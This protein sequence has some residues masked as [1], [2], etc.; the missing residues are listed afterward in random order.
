MSKR[1]LSIFVMLVLGFALIGCTGDTPDP[2]PNPDPEEGVLTWSGLEDE[3]IVRGDAVDLLDGI[4]VVDSIDG[5]LTDGITVKDDGSF[6]THFAD[7]YTVTYEV[8]NSTG[9][10]EEKTKQFSVVVAH[11]LA[12]NDFEM[13]NTYGWTSDKP[14]G[15][16]DVT[17]ADGEAQISI[18]NAG[19]AWWAL[20]LYQSNI[21]FQSGVTYKITMHASSPDGHSLAVGF[22]DPND[23]FSMLMP[24]TVSF[25]LTEDSTEYV[26]YYTADKD[27]AN[28]KVVFYLGY[29]LDGDLVEDSESPH[30][31]NIQDINIETIDV[32]ES[33]TFAG[34]DT[35]S[36]AS[37]EFTYDL[38][39][40]MSA[41]NGETDLTSDVQ[42]IG[43]L[44]EEVRDAGANSIIQY[45]INH[46]DGS[47]SFAN[48]IF[49]YYISKEADYSTVNGSFDG[50]M[51]GWV[52]DVNQT[53]GTG[54]ATFTDNHDG[55]V[56]ILV[57][58]ESTAGWHI[59]LQQEQS[60][61]TAGETYRVY[62]RLKASAERVVTIE[63][64][65]PSAGWRNLVD[66]INPTLTTE[67]Q[68]FELVFTADS[69]LTAKVG[70]LLGKNGESAN[71]IT[72]TVDEFQVYLDSDDEAPVITG[73]EDFT[74]TV[75]DTEPN[76]LADV[77]ATDNLSPNVEVTVKETDVDLNTAGSYSLTYA[78]VD[79]AGNEATV[80]VSV[81]VEEA[82]ND[83][84]VW[85]GLDAVDVLNGDDTFDLLAGVT[86]K[87]HLDND[88][89]ASLTIS[90]LGGF[91][92][93]IAGTYSVV[94]SAENSAETV[95]TQT[96]LVTVGPKFTADQENFDEQGAWVYDNIT[97]S[98]SEGV[99]TI[100]F[101]STPGGDPW[102]HQLYQN[103]GITLLAG[104]TYQVEVR[105]KSSVARDVRAWIEDVNNGYSGI[106]TDD[107]T[108]ISLEADTWTVLTYT[109]E[110][111]EAIDTTNAKYVVMLG[112]AGGD[113]GAHT[114][115]VDYFLVTDITE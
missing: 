31:V 61:L 87:D 53:Q 55:T 115:E 6:S 110:I 9:V 74:L 4:S 78:A 103:P 72:V 98:L 71:D 54:A 23:G 49:D 20:Q 66:P 37:G 8:E 5:D 48:R 88:I 95:Y 82:A 33:V 112:R 43:Y 52:A 45:V 94:Y 63:V 51:L 73:A 44:P 57:E 16:F 26:M 93:N 86:V 10:T 1:I 89:T 62:V 80:T 27:Y 7:V 12:N 36:A 70:I 113:V 65:Q 13:N 19:S 29:K 100:T 17:F 105:V 85:S 76:W 28:V 11:N 92:V 14:G 96:R 47:V 77:A 59:Q 38:F 91:D 81:T 114:V 15:D 106:A 102:N 109:I 2:D 22:E 58:N 30:L 32:N 90:D 68:E 34:I 46:E 99:V 3:T 40:G 83:A 64:T 75:G 24:G 67:Y 107:R 39:D 18:S 21:I 79:L 108:M 50:G 56:S 60:Q 104:H 25:Q 69:D 111:T 41:M 42:T 35:V 84:F 97:A 101:D